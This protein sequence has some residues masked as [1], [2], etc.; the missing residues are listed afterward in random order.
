MDD[1]T[2]GRAGVRAMALGA[3][4]EMIDDFEIAYSEG[5]IHVLN[6]PSCR[7]FGLSHWKSNSRHGPHTF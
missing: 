3:D 7:N 4:G 6:A 1:I 5:S 2:P